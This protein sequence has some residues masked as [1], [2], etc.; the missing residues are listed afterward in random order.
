M[1][2][3]ISRRWAAAAY[4][5]LLLVAMWLVGALLASFFQEALH[6]ADGG[7]WH[8]LLRAWFFLIGLLYFG[9]SWTHGG[10]TIGMKAWRLRVLRID[11]RP[12]RWP[13]ATAR[14]TAMLVLWTL[15]LAPLLLFAPAVRSAHAWVEPT[16]WICLAA[17]PLA[18]L[19]SRLDPM[20]LTPLDR[21]TG[22]RVIRLPRET[23]GTPP[24][25][26]QVSA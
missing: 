22:S 25:P 7:R 5:A 1:P 8:H 11:G 12:L 15:S 13:I 4:D 17:L 9:L 18:V 16:A 2:A 24:R 20:R 26:P 23:T 10:Q 21:V 14:Y 19:W 3:A 6:I